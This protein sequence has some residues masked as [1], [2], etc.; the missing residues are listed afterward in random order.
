M[1]KFSVAAFVSQTV[2]G[3]QQTGYALLSNG[4]WMTRSSG[5]HIWA[6]TEAR[7][8][9][10]AHKASDKASTT[11]PEFVRWGALVKAV[12]LATQHAAPVVAAPGPFATVAPAPVAAPVVVAPVVVAPVAATVQAAS[13]AAAA[14]KKP[15]T[16]AQCAATLKLTST[17]AL[18]CERKE[19][20]GDLNKARKAVATAF[21][22]YVAACK[23]AGV[24]VDADLAENARF[25]AGFDDVA[26][27]AAIGE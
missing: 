1:S 23:M 17:N 24:A 3:Y 12:P 8:F 10:L 21:G 6:M 11:P 22:N 5:S 18:R 26:D 27:D 14:P 19:I 20:G 25:A 4:F 2:N 16:V 7:A 9:D 13:A 15:R